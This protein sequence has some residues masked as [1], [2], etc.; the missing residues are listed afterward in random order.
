V[1]PAWEFL[2]TF[3]SPSVEINPFLKE[4]L[5]RFGFKETSFFNGDI[6]KIYIGF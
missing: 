1:L 4:C 6:R 5:D 3:S 2:I